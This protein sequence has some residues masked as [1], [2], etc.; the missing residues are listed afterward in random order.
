VIAGILHQDRPGPS[1]A[2]DRGG[3][4]LFRGSARVGPGVDPRPPRSNLRRC[5]PLNVSRSRQAED[6]SRCAGRSRQVR[7]WPSRR[8]LCLRHQ[9]STLSGLTRAF[10]F[11]PSSS[12]IQRSTALACQCCDG[13]QLGAGRK[14]GSR[15]TGASRCRRFLVIAY[16]ALR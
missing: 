2:K 1:L 4:F 6:R 11:I 12:A 16:D 10:R 8:L 13:V 7:P 14:L 15:E 3:L 5:S 9:D